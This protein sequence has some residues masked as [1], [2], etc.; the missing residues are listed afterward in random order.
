MIKSS[1]SKL[2]S[3]I[4]ALRPIIYIPT[5]DFNAFDNLIEQIKDNYVVR[6]FNEGLGYVNFKT[7]KIET[8]YSLDQFLALQTDY[9]PEPTFLLLK[10]IHHHLNDPKVIS[11][12]KTIALR[13]IYDDDYYVT[14]FIVSTKLVIPVEL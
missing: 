10:D 13:N 1:F 14:V 7:K 2:A 9:V 6:E 4:E 3:Y 5:F 8:K 11:L 12:L